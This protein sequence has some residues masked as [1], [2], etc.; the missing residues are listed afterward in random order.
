MAMLD[1]GLAAL[2]EVETRVLVRAIAVNIEIMRAF[3]RLRLLVASNKDLA[4]RLDR[5]EAKTDAKFTTVFEAISQLMA[6]PEP[7]DRPMD[8]VVAKEK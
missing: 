4:R 2:Y 7:K 1:A 8:F 3:V 5:L 6:L